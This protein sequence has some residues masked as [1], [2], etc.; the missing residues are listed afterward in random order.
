MKKQQHPEGMNSTAIKLSDYIPFK[1]TISSLDHT[2]RLLILYHLPQLLSTKFSGYFSQKLS[3][4][5]L[6]I[7]GYC[8]NNLYWRQFTHSA[9]VYKY[10]PLCVYHFLFGGDT[11]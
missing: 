3:S 5:P 6:D 7:A 9:I 10:L 11:Y 8:Y 1:T 2:R 4:L